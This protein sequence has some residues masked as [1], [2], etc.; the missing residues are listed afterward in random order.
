MRFTPVPSKL[1]S[2]GRVR[3]KEATAVDVGVSQQHSRV[4]RV[5]LTNIRL[6]PFGAMLVATIIGAAIR[7]ST[8]DLQS[9]WDDEGF[10]VTLMR[11][12]FVD[13]L[14][15]VRETEGSPPLYYVLAWGWAQIFGT[16]E[17]GL[18]SLSAV[19][20]TATVPVAYFAGCT[21]GSRRGAAVAA[22]LVAASPLLVWYSQEARTYALFGLLSALSF[23]TF[24]RALRGEQR[25]L[26]WWA[27]TA[28]LALASHYFAAFIVAAEAAWLLVSLGVRRATV[29]AVGAV[30]IVAVALAP[31]ALHQ[32][33]RAG[34]LLSTPLE[35]RVAQVPV[36]F[37][38]GYGVSAMLVGRLALAAGA[39]LIGIGAWLLVARAAEEIRRGA[40]LAAALAAVAVA[41]PVFVA[42]VAT[43]YL[44]TLYLIGALPLAAIAVAQGFGTTR[45]GLLAAA[46]LVAIGLSITGLVAATPRLQRPDLR[47]IASALGSPAAD[48]A[49][50]I[51]PT[52]R[53]DVYM[54]G[55]QRFPSR[56]QPVAE[57]VFVAQP[58]KE[59]GELAVVPRTLSRPFAVQGFESSGR[60]LADRFTIL[61]FRASRPRHVTREEL[62]R[63]SFPEWPRELTSVVTQT[64]P[65]S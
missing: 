10:T 65:G 22:F 16:G 9:F 64:G 5:H 56:A 61:R 45:G 25:S 7:L 63:A 4:Q 53:I 26:I 27:A 12:S 49:I 43:D 1:A 30:A 40:G 3:P 60:L 55:L 17:W 15:G 33:D 35:T 58:V 23:L 57:V 18:R 41:M 31:L 14:Q 47:G 36:Q 54:K 59:P 48:R 20:G 28:A 13:M 46:L 2:V 38:V 51:A 19:V 44:K 6:D 42:Y 11:L 21:I 62:L 39:V 29:A 32:S 52:S 34:G 50:V 37:L 24:A 8:V